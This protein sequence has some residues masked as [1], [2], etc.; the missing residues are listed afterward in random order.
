MQKAELGLLGRRLETSQ[1]PTGR[2]TFFQVEPDENEGVSTGGSEPLP[3]LVAIG[4]LSRV[5]SC[6][7][8]SL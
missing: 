5:K 6:T 1:C 4:L 7:S 2:E 3:K 8:E